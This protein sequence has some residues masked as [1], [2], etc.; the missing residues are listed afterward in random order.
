M[1]A[2]G[3]RAIPTID[4]ER[5]ASA[6]ALLE[7]MLEKA[8]AGECVDIVATYIDG[9]GKVALD[10]SGCRDVPSRLGDL[11]LMMH[12]LRNEAVADVARDPG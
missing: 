9:E 12:L 7:D 6:I 5:Q 8:K 10:Y 11:D 3:F 4:E 1:T 2:H